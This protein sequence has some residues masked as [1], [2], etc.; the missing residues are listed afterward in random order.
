MLPGSL[1]VACIGLGRIGSGI[2]HSIQNAGYPLIVYNRT[3]QK[4]QALV[5]AGATSAESPREAVAAADIVI[6][7]LM[8]DAS[9]LDNLAGPDGILA[10]MR[11]HSIHIGTSTISPK[12]TAQ[13]S[14]LHRAHGS[15][16]L[17]APVAGHPHHAA[18][19]KLLSFVAGDSEAFERARPV[20]E[21][22]SAKIVQLGDAPALASSFKLVVNFFA[23]S[24]LETIGEAFIFAEKQGIDLV[25]MSGMLKDLLQH[26]GFPAYLE[27]IRTR[28]FEE[29]LGSTLDGAGSK[30]VRI[31]LQT[32]AEVHV[33]LPIASLVR[34]KIVAA[35]SLGFGEHDWSVLTEISRLNAGELPIA[36]AKSAG[37]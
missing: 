36:T 29:I 3:P 16:Y 10:G 11:P 25:V 27:K 17:A 18:A 31:I 14:K 5:A 34:D 20:L 33:P 4:A 22:Y 8:D 26:P 13:L 2:A 28:N 32:A 19:G 21:A 7:S 9:V 30:D 1:T 24:L 23:A 37:K 35:Q 6:T 12:G 15:H